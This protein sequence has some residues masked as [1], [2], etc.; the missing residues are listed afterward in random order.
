M[1]AVAKE[2]RK[3]KR[4]TK[5]NNNNLNNSQILHKKFDFTKY[6]F[7]IRL[8]HVSGF[9]PYQIMVNEFQEIKNNEKRAGFHWH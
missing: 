9:N 7:Y 3:K 8:Q 4:T 5:I 2:K 6:Y 1:S